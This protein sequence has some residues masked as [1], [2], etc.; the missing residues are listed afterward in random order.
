MWI[1]YN[2]GVEVGR[3]SRVTLTDG[4]L[5]GRDANDRIQAIYSPRGW[6]SAKWS[7]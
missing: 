5:R 3:H 2:E 1:I 7:D 6:T 4:I